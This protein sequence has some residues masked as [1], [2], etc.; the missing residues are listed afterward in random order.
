[1]GT[2][3]DAFTGTMKSRF[4]GENNSDEGKVVVDGV[5]RQVTVNATASDRGAHYTLDGQEVGW[6]TPTHEALD[7]Y[8]T[9]IWPP[10][11]GD[12]DAVVEAG[13]VKSV[14][15]SEED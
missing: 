13:V 10:E 15:P 8:F 14:T 9:D 5:E 1:M 12:W 7:L 3:V 4:D 6:D 2:T 11:D